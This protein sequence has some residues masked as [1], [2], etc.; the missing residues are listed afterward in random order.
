MVLPP[1][2]A[3]VIDIRGPL[4]GS[5]GEAPEVDWVER[6]DTGLG[7]AQLGWRHGRTAEPTSSAPLVL[8]PYDLHGGVLARG[9]YGGR[10]GPA[11]G[12]GFEVGGLIPTGVDLAIELLPVGI[13]VGLWRSGF[14]ALTGGV[15][16]IFSS[17][18]PHAL[19]LFPTELRA[20]IDLGPR[21]RVIAA[22]ELRWSSV[23]SGGR[24]A[25]PGTDGYA[26]SLALRRG[27]SSAWEGWSRGRFVGI[28]VWEQRGVPFLGFTMGVQLT[29]SD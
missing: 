7:S 11:F 20:E 3:Q 23:G 12:L 26:A 29:A 28:A 2:P 4:P 22:G 18:E 8:G 5:S 10:L 14:L 24:G 13:G 25:I 9:Y 16:P 1:V 6:R 17:Y 15:R 27:G 19:A 21:W